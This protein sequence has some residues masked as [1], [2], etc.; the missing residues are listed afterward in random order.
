MPYVNE[1]AF[2][3][4]DKMVD[5]RYISQPLTVDLLSD[6]C[7]LVKREADSLSIMQNVASYMTMPNTKYEKVAG[8]I[9]ATEL[10]ECY[11]AKTNKLLELRDEQEWVHLVEKANNLNRKAYIEKVFDDLEAECKE[12]FIYFSAKQKADMVRKEFD[13]LA[14][15]HEEVL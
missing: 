2:A 12:N 13:R 8:R 10:I 15:E 11:V 7:K 5:K 4:S 1:H 14:K 9:S 6:S 3:R